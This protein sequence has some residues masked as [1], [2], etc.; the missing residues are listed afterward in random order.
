MDQCELHRFGYIYLQW[1]KFQIEVKTLTFH[2]L[3]K[4]LVYSRPSTSQ[5]GKR[6]GGTKLEEN[7]CKKFVRN[8]NLK[9]LGG[10][11]YF[12]YVF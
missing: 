10:N 2:I 4:N 1:M 8:L 6:G 9:I 3:Q 11:I 12:S 5:V 7:Y